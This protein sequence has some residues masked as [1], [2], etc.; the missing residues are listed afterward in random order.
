MSRVSLS[1]LIM[2]A[3]ISL[4]VS[5]LLAFAVSFL[6]FIAWAYTDRKR[7]EDLVEHIDAKID[8]AKTSI[9]DAMKGEGHA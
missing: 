5:I 8:D 1:A 3:G 6:M 2:G 9:I 4:S 7:R